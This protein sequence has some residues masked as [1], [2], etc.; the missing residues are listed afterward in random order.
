VSRRARLGLQVALSLAALAL[1]AWLVDLEAAL[2]ALADI[3]AGW[4]VAAVALNTVL[5]LPMALRWQLLL[6]A[7]GRRISL[8]WATGATFVSMLFG[9][10]LPSALGAD[11]VRAVDLARQTGERAEAASSVIVDRVLGLIGTLLLAA[12]GIAL[13]GAA[14]GGGAAVA[15]AVVLAA[16]ILVAGWLCFSRRAPALVA[17]L[18]PLAGR[19][20]VATPIAS[21][22]RAVHAYRAHPQTLLLVTAIAAAAQVGRVAVVWM[23]ARGLGLDVAAGALLVLVPVVFLVTSLPISLNGIGVREA[24]FAAVLAEDGVTRS[25]AVAL[26]IAFFT[27]FVL[28]GLVGGLVLLWRAFRPA[29]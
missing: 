5:T 2:D 20:R 29:R 27:A 3:D 11:A 28:T 15:A 4:A 23:L 6:R 13:G 7:I 14:A 16:A 22:W 21:L 9:Q 17:P 26:G 8:A 1:V 19:L 18:A 10:V 25:D 24:A 12:A